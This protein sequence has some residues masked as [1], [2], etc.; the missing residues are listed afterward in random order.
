MCIYIYGCVYISIFYFINFGN[1]NLLYS[2]LYWQKKN[3]R[4]EGEEEEEEEE[5]EGEKEARSPY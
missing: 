3:G 5:V 2:E 4:K 1:Y